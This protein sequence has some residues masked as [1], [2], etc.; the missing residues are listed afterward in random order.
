MLGGVETD[1]STT[2]NSDGDGNRNAD[3]TGARGVVSVYALL[4]D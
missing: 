2:P 1:V 3:E 4:I